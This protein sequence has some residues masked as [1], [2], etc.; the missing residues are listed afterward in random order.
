MNRTR[1]PNRTFAHIPPPTKLIS[2]WQ[3]DTSTPLP[4]AVDMSSHYLPAIDQGDHGGACVCHAT[5]EYLS[6]LR[7]LLGL[8]DLGRLSRL[9]VYFNGLKA[10]YATRPASQWPDGI[11][12]AAAFDVATVQGVPEEFYW[13]YVLSR[14][15]DTPPTPAYVA[16][17]R[18]RITGYASLYNA[19]NSSDDKYGPAHSHYDLDLLKRAVQQRSGFVWAFAVTGEGLYLVN[20]FLAPA[21]GPTDPQS[22]SHCVVAIAYDD[23]QEAFVFLNSYGTGWGNHGTG[24]VRYSDILR[25]TWAYGMTIADGFSWRS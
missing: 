24:K 25:P 13:P 16:A 22:D 2:S 5:T 11:S 6:A 9:F 8:P 18:N 15:H 12:V 19:R 21:Q 17:R 4:S 23:S 20:G 1:P 7:S 3:P 10:M 14:Y